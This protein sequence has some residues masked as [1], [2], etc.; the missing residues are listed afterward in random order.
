M[1]RDIVVLTHGHCFDGLAS[2]AAFTRYLRVLE[3]GVARNF[4]YKSCGYG[5]GMQVIPESWLEGE[6]NAILDFR[7]T[8]S[9]KLSFY[10]DHHITAFASNEEQ[11]SALARPGVFFDPTYGSCTKLIADVAASRGVVLDADLIAW[12]DIIDAARFDSA[13]A[14]TAREEPV[15]QLASVVEHHGDAGFLGRTID[16]LLRDGLEA[17]AKSA[18]IQAKFAP[19]GEAQRAFRER[20]GRRAAVKGRVVAVDLTEAPLEVAAKFVTYALYPECMYSVTLTRSQKHFKLSVGY[21]PWCGRTREHDIASIC[22]RY[23]GGGHPPVGA[24]SFPLSAEEKARA[25]FAAVVEEL[26]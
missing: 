9:K 4:R 12:A 18:D 7:Y 21:N 14:A 20:V 23:D 6:E 8:P 26:S 10:F 16:A 25:A 3:P 19:I 2:A 17:V 15:L 11:E 5:P 1:P 13:E 22:R 24:C